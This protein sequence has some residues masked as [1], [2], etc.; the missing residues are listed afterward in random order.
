ML[1]G[2]SSSAFTQFPVRQTILFIVDWTPAYTPW[3][4]NRCRPRKT[5]HDPA[6][7]QRIGS[8]MAVPSYRAWDRVTTAI[9]D[10]QHAAAV[11]IGVV[12][13]G[14]TSGAAYMIVPRSA[15]VQVLWDGWAL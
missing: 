13:W 10:C 14:S 5:P 15:W 9:W 12:D 11:S 7:S 2:W 6:A 4:W 3:D 1:T 8:P